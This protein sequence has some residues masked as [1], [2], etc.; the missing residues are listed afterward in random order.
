MEKF[1][2]QWEESNGKTDITRYYT[3][4]WPSDRANALLDISPEAFFNGLPAF[5]QD[6]LAQSLTTKMESGG[7]MAPAYLQLLTSPSFAAKY[8][9]RGQQTGTGR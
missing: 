5:A 7:D 6:Y 3:S 1:R 8:G 4:Q 9:A 2:L